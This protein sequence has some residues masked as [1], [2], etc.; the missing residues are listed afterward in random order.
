MQQ[1]LRDY[2]HTAIRVGC[3]RLRYERIRPMSELVQCITKRNVYANFRQNRM[4]RSQVGARKTNS[5]RGRLGVALLRAGDTRR[6]VITV[7]ITVY[8]I[9]P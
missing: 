3:M 9:S 2:H 8:C 6:D 1:Y 4:I 5:G 7:Y